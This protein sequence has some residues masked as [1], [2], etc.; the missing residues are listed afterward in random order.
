MKKILSTLLISIMLFSAALTPNIVNAQQKPVHDKVCGRKIGQLVSDE[1]KLW[2]EH[3]LWTRSFI[4]SDLEGLEDKQNVLDRLLKNQGDIGSSI[5]P[6]FGNEAGEKLTSLLKEHILIGGQV[7]DAVKSG[8]KADIDKYSKLWYK[9]A[10]AITDYLNSINPDW[11]K[12]E[13]KDL[14]YKHLQLITEQVISEKNKDWSANIAAFDAG[15]EHILKLA[16]TLSHGI[17]KKFPDNFRANE[18]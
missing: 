14:L 7:V 17:I 3:V 6:Y 12:S 1:R 15:E 5:K 10:D 11:S 2:L 13:L 16:D 9:N 18:E 8:N 4:T